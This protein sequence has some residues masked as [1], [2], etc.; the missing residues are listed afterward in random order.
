[1]KRYYIPILTVLLGISLFGCGKKADN[2][3]VKFDT[4]GF[5]K[6]LPL[7]KFLMMTSDTSRSGTGRP[8]TIITPP[9]IVGP[10]N[11]PIQLTVPAGAVPDNI[12]LHVSFS[13]TDPADGVLQMV[14]VNGA[15]ASPIVYASQNVAVAGAVVH[16]LPPGI[17]GE[18]DYVPAAGQTTNITA[19]LRAGGTAYDA[20]TS[21][22]TPNVAG[23]ITSGQVTSVYSDNGNNHQAVITVSCAPGP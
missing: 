10:N 20:V 22:P 13:E 19:Y 8:T 9:S 7:H 17:I 14:T 4:A 1:M 11:N 5:V 12:T 21:L 6:Q 16:V 18:W 2:D 23:K 15:A 3:L